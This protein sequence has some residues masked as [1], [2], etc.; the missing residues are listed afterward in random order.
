LS[1]LKKKN[2]SSQPPTARGDVFECA[3]RFLDYRPR[4]AAEARDHLISRGY[5]AT[6]VA[7]TLE[8]LRSLSY[9]DDEKFARNWAVS[10]FISRGYGPKRIEQ[11][12]RS[13]GI[14]EALIRDVLREICDPGSE[15][16]RARS[17]LEKK[18]ASQKLADPTV[19]R[20]AI[21]FLQRRG[22]SSEVIFALLKYPA[23]DD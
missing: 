9:L 10:K 7:T 4:S 12:L 1:K 23:Q 21:G 5:S 18:F 14:R 11:E 19:V 6:A 13:R 22:Y 2:L 17:L 8:K 16:E 3:L 20:R 15:A